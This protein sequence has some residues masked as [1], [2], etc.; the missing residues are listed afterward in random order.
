MGP[1]ISYLNSTLGKISNLLAL[2]LKNI[3]DFRNGIFWIIVDAV[4]GLIALWVSMSAVIIFRLD[5][6]YSRFFLFRL[7][8]WLADFMMPILGSLCFIPFV[9]I[10]LDIFVCDHSIGD[11][12][13]DSFLSY[14]C[15]YFCWK[16]EHLIYAILSFFALLCYEP[17]AVFC[18]P[19][20]QELQP[21]LHVKSSP[22][23][24]MVK[25][26][27]QVLLIAMNKTV[28]R[29]QD[30]T[31]RILFIFVMIFYVVFLLKFKPYNYP[32]FNLWQNLSLI[33]VVWLA[34]L[35]TIALGVKVN[36][37]ILTILL[38]IGWLIIV[39]YGLYIQKKKYPS[40]LFRKKHHDITS[41]F[42]FAF[43]F[44]KHSHKAL[45]KIIPSSN[46]LERQDKN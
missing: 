40:L 14:D 10:C 23:F 3:I 35:S 31:H 36:S 34:I 20:W 26:V 45:N 15:Y 38:F 5:E 1:D 29:A 11:N 24:L 9:P 44:G 12:F 39:L 18:R 6:K 21:M 42:K 22:Y 2:E 46:S 27:I 28:R 43:T 17:L 30:I 4:Y 41:L 33:G 16:D 7:I 32:R 13:T 37:I 19:L 25:T 8:D